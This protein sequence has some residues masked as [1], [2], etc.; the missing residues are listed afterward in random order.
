VGGR[1]RTFVEDPTANCRY[2]NDILSNFA[3]LSCARRC[4]TKR[5]NCPRLW[6]EYKLLMFRPPNLTELKTIERA[7]CL[8]NCIFGRN[9]ARVGDSNR[10][11]SVSDRVNAGKGWPSLGSR[12]LL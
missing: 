9:A 7:I 11:Q 3:V 4:P 1:S 5:V 2:D 12:Y 10:L 8:F 6:I